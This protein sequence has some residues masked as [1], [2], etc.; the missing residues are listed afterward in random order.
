MDIIGEL[1]RHIAKTRYEDI[2]TDV[3][4]FTKKALIDTVGVLL[5]GTALIEGQ[6]ITDVVKEWGGKEE[7][8]VINYGFKVPVHHAALANG[9]MARVVD[10]DDVLERAALHVHASIVSS[11]ISVAEKIG[12]VNGKDLL[13]S[14]ILGTDLHCRLGLSNKIPTA[15]SGMNSSYQYGTFGVAATSGKLLGLDEDKLWNAMGIAYSLTSGNSQCLTE[16]AMTTRLGQGTCAHAGVLSTLL[17]HKGFTGVR[18]VLQ[19]K[20][21]Y[22]SCYQRGEYYPEALTDALGKRFEGLDVT[23]KRYACCLHTH[24]AIEGT[25]NLIERN[26][27]KPKDI[28]EIHVG[29]NQQAYNLVVEPID[30]KF[31]PH[32]VAA[33]QFSLPFT[34]GTAVLKKKAFIDDF[35]EKEIRNPQV[36]EIAKKVRASVDPEI[37]RTS[38]GRV[39]PAK[40][41]ISTYSGQEFSEK[42]EFIKGHPNNPISFDELVNKFRMCNSFANN[43]LSNERVEE[44]IETVL[45]LENVKEVN[46]LIRVLG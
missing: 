39:T 43:P 22:F 11:A 38:S 28:K 42:V 41:R 5:A 24:A 35:T 2:P 44:F 33:A 7:S 8:S 19:G 18:N 6:M 12:K 20:F 13:T 46:Q 25:L 27:I 40:V 14:I 37:E 3:V 15:I 34:Q 17:A 29:V 21:G 32:E 31:D 1:V 9:T 36:L 23:F 26:N 10:M 4:D 30:I 16:G 45:K